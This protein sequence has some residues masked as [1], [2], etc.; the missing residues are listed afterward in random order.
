M[1]VLGITGMGKTTAV[2]GLCDKLGLAQQVVALDPSGDYL[3]FHDGT[4]WAD[5]QMDESGFHVYE[6]DGSPAVAT[7]DFLEAMMIH[8]KKQYLQGEI[9]ER[10]LC[11]EEAHASLPEPTAI[12]GDERAASTESGKLL[13]QARKYGIHYLLVS[14][15]TSVVSKSALSQCES[16][17]VFR[18]VDETTVNY[19]ES[20]MGRNV[21][22]VLLSLG[23]YEALCFGPAFNLDG[24][25]V[26][27]M[28][29]PSTT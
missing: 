28:D 21:R 23:R 2:V 8:A 15:R 12:A 19:L 26:I 11:F 13:L 10:L 25:A 18:N 27:Q 14:Q 9:V 29:A 5:D 16:L 7:K 3:R 1:A 22:D 20:V 17:I 6:L 4:A 24:L